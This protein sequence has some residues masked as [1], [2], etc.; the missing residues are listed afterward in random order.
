MVGFCRSLLRS[1]RFVQCGDYVNMSHIS[2]TRLF[3]DSGV[4]KIGGT[5]R[6]AAGIMTGIVTECNIV[7]PGVAGPANALFWRDTSVWG[8]VLKFRS[9]TAVVGAG[10]ISFLLR[11]Q[12]EIPQ[13]G[14]TTP[15]KKNAA[16]L[17]QVTSPLA[18]SFCW[19]FWYVLSAFPWI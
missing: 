12:V 17:T 5:R 13:D 6:C 14:D 11:C 3:Q 1:L 9:I 7:S 15:K 4:I 8:A 10:G 19:A 18:S 2:P 16:Y